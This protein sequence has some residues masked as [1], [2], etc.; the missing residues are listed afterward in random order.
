MRGMILNLFVTAAEAVTNTL[1]WALLYLS[2]YP[3]VQDKLGN[4]ILNV[5]GSD[6]SPSLG[7]L[8]K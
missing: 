4:E 7:D 6:R 8:E 5:I 3:E 2:L 1:N